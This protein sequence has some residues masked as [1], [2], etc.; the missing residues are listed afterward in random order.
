M[1]PS[2]QVPGVL[3]GY[4]GT[5]CGSPVP[6]AGPGSPSKTA[7]KLK[8]HKASRAGKTRCRTAPATSSG[9]PRPMNA[10]MLWQREH[11]PMVLQRSPELQN[12]MVS[13]KLGE[14]WKAAVLR[15]PEMK[16]RYQ[17]KERVEKAAHARR[18]PNYKYQPRKRKTTAGRPA[19]KKTAK[20]RPSRRSRQVQNHIESD[21]EDSGLCDSPTPDR[22]RT[23]TSRLSPRGRLNT[24]EFSGM[25]QDFAETLEDMNT[26]PTFPTCDFD[27]AMK[28]PALDDD[29]N[30]EEDVFSQ[31]V[32]SSKSTMVIDGLLYSLV[33]TVPQ[34]TKSVKKRTP[35]FSRKRIPSIMTELNALMEAPEI[36][37]I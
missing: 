35:S 19:T 13:I 18:Y 36:A 4:Y 8:R 16:A 33:P 28:L 31:V 23:K 7:M 1:P 11:R 10:F 21:G 12:H 24:E 34:T 5:E 30:I 15:D 2:C 20:P 27:N 29:L 9:P 14:L 22:S 6:D 32:P 3:P 37:G 26:V 17:A 25:L